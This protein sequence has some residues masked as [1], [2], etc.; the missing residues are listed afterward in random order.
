MREIKF[1]IWNGN[2][3]KMLIENFWDDKADVL[4]PFTDYEKDYLF[5]EQYIGQKDKNGKEIYEGDIVRNKWG[6]IGKIVFGGGAFVSVYIPPYNWDP[7]QPVD[8]IMS[9]QEILGNIWEN[10][11]LLEQAK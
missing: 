1:R 8:G 10:P 7:M 11:E 3:K 9:E 6:E 2:V 5:P 4:N